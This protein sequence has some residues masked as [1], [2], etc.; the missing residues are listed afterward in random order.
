MVLRYGGTVDKFTGDGVMAVFGAPVSLE[1]HAL[2]ACLAALGIQ[3]EAKRLATEVQDRD[4][5]DLLLRVGLNSGQVIAGEIGSGVSGYTAIGEQVGLAQRM[6]SVAPPG[7]VLLSESTAHFVEHATLLGDPELVRIKG[8]DSPVPAR[9]LLAIQPRHALVGR[10]ESSMVGRRAEMAAVEAIMER[11]IGGRGAVV[12]VVG[13]PGLGKSR[14]ARQ[15]GALAARRGVGVFWTFCES[16]ASDIPFGVVTRLLRAASGIGD[17]DG[18]AARVR[19][20]GQIRAADEQ[21]L[22][23]LDDLLGIA[24]RDVPPPAIDPD[25]RRRRLTAMINTASLARTDP[26]LYIIE[27]AQW[28]D[29]VS[30]SMLADI[31]TVIPHTSS[32]VLIT[33]RPEYQGALARVAGAQTIALAPLSDSATTSLLGELLGDDPS[34]IGLAATIVSRVGGNPFFAEEMVRDLAERGVLGGQ[35]GAYLC[36]TDVTATG[37]PATL[38]AT[39]GAR[40]DRLDRMAK[41]ALSAAAVIG[42]RFGTELLTSLGVEPVLE[43]LVRA[44]LIDQVRI[45]PRAEYAFRHPLVRAV[46]YESQL[47]SD[48]AEMHRRLAAAIQERDPGSAD[49]NAALIAEC[50]PPAI[51]MPRMAGTCAPARGRPTAISPPRGSVGNGPARSPIGCPATI[52]IAPRC[53]SLP[54]PCCASA[55]GE[56]SKRTAQGASRNCGSCARSPAT[57]PRWPSA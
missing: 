32:M 5:V 6:E 46:A 43:E 55:P 45:T 44:E 35:R 26:A 36:R 1:D 42:S 47:K 21:D 12:E 24:D 40:I 48:R 18:P 20:R 13:P 3:E 28:I 29:G 2:R 37:V 8:A 9:R 39:I 53:V 51:C 30:E 50:R 10:A 7:A 14:V 49:A 54:A 34:V 16:Y 4:N 22:L 19:V 25:A 33:Y 15:A 38:Q 41:R 27:D 52:R 56:Q 57:K 17:L 31:L 23:L 11:A